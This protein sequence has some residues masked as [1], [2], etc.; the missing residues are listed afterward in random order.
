ME[1]FEPL[2]VDLSTFEKKVK[3]KKNLI[4][5]DLL[6]LNS[7]K[8]TPKVAGMVAGLV[9][10][11]LKKHQPE[12][13]HSQLID[14]LLVDKLRELGLAK[15]DLH[16][17]RSLIQENES[18]SPDV[19]DL[20][21]QS[22]EKEIVEESPHAA[23][24]APPPTKEPHRLNPEVLKAIWPAVSVDVGLSNLCQRVALVD[25]KY[26][27][28]ADVESTSIRFFNFIAK[29]QFIPHPFGLKNFEQ[30]QSFSVFE[31]QW[32]I[33]EDAEKFQQVLG[34]VIPFLTQGGK[35]VFKASSKDDFLFLQALEAT[36]R[37]LD[38]KNSAKKQVVLV[39]SM[40]DVRILDVL[41][42][43]ASTFQILNLT[44][45]VMLPADFMGSVSA[46]K[47]ID[48]GETGA[49]TQ[50]V[51][52]RTLF[53]K[54][55]RQA[56]DWRGT[57]QLE[58]VGDERKEHLVAVQG[59]LNVASYYARGEIIWPRIAEAV[60]T[61]LHFLDNCL[62]MADDSR[63]SSRV[64]GINLMG[65]NELFARAQCTFESPAALNLVRKI[66]SFIV[67]HA[68]TVNKKWTDRRGPALGGNCRNRLAWCLG[69]GTW[70]AAL[71]GV[72]SG[73]NAAKGKKS[74]D[75]CFKLQRLAESFAGNSIFNPIQLQ[76]TDSEEDVSRLMLLAG[77]LGIRCLSLEGR[78]RDSK[79]L[80]VGESL[81]RLLIEEETADAPRE[82][83]A[84]SAAQPTI[85]EV[86]DYSDY[87]GLL[88]NED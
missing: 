74:P 14:E 46:N 62:E 51:R 67:D 85:Q 13:I 35:A 9:E 1:N 24:I 54:C 2:I 79:E 75:V 37:F 58:W 48:L 38:K 61:E 50:R 10:R 87:F 84:N 27:P 8:I 56:H 44:L 78:A 31:K 49:K 57:Y 81:A 88:P 33:P 29:G 41:Q 82:S 42:M 52:A 18:L 83:G 15:P 64:I 55:A 23:A 66:F 69:D 76:S 43:D 19:L 72:S 63:N 77:L 71:A 47:T 39:V 86:P 17:R 45:R 40:E 28:Y 32:A 73:L 5:E 80:T 16:A 68:Q 4:V 3:F 70:E 7:P 11:E 65:W 21:S 6:S 12:N 59:A 25:Q 26:D 34:E 30:R 53:K 20:L 36:L 22:N 60:E